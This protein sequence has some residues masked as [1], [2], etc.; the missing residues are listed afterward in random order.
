MT[1]ASTTINAVPDRRLYGA[2]VM[3]C[4][5]GFGVTQDVFLKQLSGSYPF[6][7]MQL[8]R[9]LVAA[10]FI[11]LWLF[12]KLGPNV[13]KGTWTP[14]LIV[15]GLLISF[16]SMFFYLGLVA[17]S[18]AD[19]VAIY[20]ALPLIIVVLSGILLREQV[21]FVR[22]LVAGIGFLGV[23]IAIEPTSALFDWAALLPLIATFFYAIGHMLTRK[24]DRLLHPMITAFYAASCFVVV[25][26]VLALVFGTGAYTSTAH[27]SLSFLTRGWVMPTL[28]DST[29][30]FI[31]GIL[32]VSG[33]F[34]YAESYRVAP[35]SFV[36]PFEYSSMLWAV[37]LGFVFFQDVP[38]QAMMI[39]TLIIIAAGLFLGWHERR[40]TPR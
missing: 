28:V 15:R 6:H 4:G 37:S 36:A 12:W 27:P 21:P 14:I 19:A 20:F 2:L 22:W 18:L 23:V 7:Q 30:I 31:L 29:Y 32:S 3:L 35:P 5:V 9:S 17:M 40:L 25:A 10:L 11:G 13:L 26:T 16:G 33:F 24:V 39:G 34:A 1:S 38:S 8:L